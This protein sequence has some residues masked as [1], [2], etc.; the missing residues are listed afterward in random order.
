MSRERGQKRSREPAPAPAPRTRV[1]ETAKY[2]GNVV[3][4]VFGSAI[5]AAAVLLVERQAARAHDVAQALERARDNRAAAISLFSSSIY[6]AI[7]RV[8]RHKL[9]AIEWN[10]DLGAIRDA[11]DLRIEALITTLVLPTNAGDFIADRAIPEELVGHEDALRKYARYVL[12]RRE[13]VDSVA[14]QGLCVALRARL[15]NRTEHGEAARSAVDRLRTLIRGLEDANVG[16]QCGCQRSSEAHPF[17]AACAG[18]A[19]R[20]ISS[21]TDHALEAISEDLDD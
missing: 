15:T 4:T 7:E 2:W 6:A 3:V 5:I 16:G 1:D 9:A 11:G 10:R 20:E 21:A 12:Q 8:Y 17:S 13:Y 19:M 14:A 18:A